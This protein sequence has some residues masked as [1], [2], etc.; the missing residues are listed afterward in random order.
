MTNTDTT[1]LTRRDGDT[2]EK[3]RALADDAQRAAVAAELKAALDGPYAEARDTARALIDAKGLRADD[4]LPLDEA[5]ERTMSQLFDVLST[6]SPR[7]SFRKGIFQL[8]KRQI[9]TVI[10][11]S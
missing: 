1:G 8:Q 2:P 4:T 6:G 3:L 11:K 5:R 9:R 10:S 7:G